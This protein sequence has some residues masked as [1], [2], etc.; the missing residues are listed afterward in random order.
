VRTDELA[1]SYNSKKE[2]YD[3]L[4]STDYSTFTQQHFLTSS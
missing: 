1:H 2:E 3:E 4:S